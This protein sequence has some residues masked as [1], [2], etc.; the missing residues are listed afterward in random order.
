[1][2]VAVLVSPSP[3]DGYPPV[4]HQARLLADAGYVVELLTS[5][6]PWQSRAISFSHPGVNLHVVQDRRGGALGAI[7]RLWDYVTKLAGLRR[8][9]RKAGAVEIVYE[10]TG[11]LYSDLAPHR[12]RTRILHFHETLQN[13]ESAWIERRLRSAIEGFSLAIVA[14]ADRGA[15]LR[16]QLPIDAAR[17]LVA[18]NYPTLESLQPAPRSPDDPF[19]VV[20]CGALGLNQK[21]DLII[22]SVKDWPDGARFRIIGQD[23]TPTGTLL[24]RLA[25]DEGVGDRVIFEGWVAYDQVPERLAQADLGILLLDPSF[26]QLR[27]ALG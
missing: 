23:D 7:G 26:T 18:P 15:I 12:P 6:L 22:R 5:A 20:Y 19:T 3:V 10:P 14:D 1:M 16:D 9:H 17:V 11:A 27:T 4:Q 8:K 25:Q 21:L 2:P 24:R 13:L